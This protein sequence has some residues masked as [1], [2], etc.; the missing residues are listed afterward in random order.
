M[1]D[2]SRDI[3][4]RR[5]NYIASLIFHGPDREE[6]ARL[7]PCLAS[8][9]EAIEPGDR[10]LLEFPRARLLAANKALNLLTR[11]TRDLFGPEHQSLIE[12]SIAFLI[13]QIGAGRFMFDP[14][15]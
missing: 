14:N 9:A 1:K 2:L 6:R 13:N 5:H 4:E 10:L 15:G 8:P 7:E 11:G 3:A 12:P